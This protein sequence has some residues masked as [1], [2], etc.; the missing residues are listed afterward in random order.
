M[1]TATASGADTV[2]T[3][4]EVDL[5]AV[6]VTVSALEAMDLEVTTVVADTAVAATVDLA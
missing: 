3:E 5:E 1:V 4:A 6:T 2:V